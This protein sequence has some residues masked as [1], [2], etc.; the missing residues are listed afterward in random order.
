MHLTRL[1]GFLFGK[2]S[3]F[4]EFLGI[5]R[6]PIISHWS[7]SS[8][9]V[10]LHLSY[11]CCNPSFF[12][13]QG[14]IRG[15]VRTVNYAKENRANRFRFLS[16]NRW[17]SVN[18]YVKIAPGND[19]TLINPIEDSEF[20][21]GGLAECGLEDLRVFTHHGDHYVIGSLASGIPLPKST[22]FIARFDPE[23]GSLSRLTPISSPVGK[24]REKNW[25]PFEWPGSEGDLHV[26]YGLSPL[27]AYRVNL[28][29][30]TYSLGE[31]RVLGGGLP[32]FYSG[33]TNMIPYKGGVLGLI[34]RRIVIGGISY[35]KH[36]F[37]Y[38]GNDL[39]ECRVSKEFFFKSRGIE[40]AVSLFLLE[41][42]I[43]IGYGVLDR[44]AWIDCYDEGLLLR[45]GLC[46]PTDSQSK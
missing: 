13:Y 20:R 33:G 22:V 18:Y 25:M 6:A 37:L 28:E 29:K 24:S 11:N 1:L 16:G 9:R 45:L 12:P 41:A 39:C 10:D 30:E 35:Y 8:T 2:F 19:V 3:S 15:I 34:H 21:T 27:T 17:D 46:F 38:L 36:A 14:E 40:F 23:S 7:H 44:E 42:K 31:K 43:H 5:L 26:I 32:H 4:F